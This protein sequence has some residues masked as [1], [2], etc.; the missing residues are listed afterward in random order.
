MI[1]QE[2]ALL[3]KLLPGEDGSNY[4]VRW[5]TPSSRKTEPGTKLLGTF[6]G[7]FVPCTS[8][9]FGMVVFLLLG[10]VVGEAGLYLTLVVLGLSFLLSLLTVIAMCALIADAGTHSPTPGLSRAHTAIIM[11]EFALASLRFK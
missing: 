3:A 8:S 4:G 10:F 6:L 1:P 2:S 9:T 5:R 11:L 7:V